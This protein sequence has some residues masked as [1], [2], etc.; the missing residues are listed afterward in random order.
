MN[1]DTSGILKKKILNRRLR[2]EG[3]LEF[4][5]TSLA[6]TK[7]QPVT[8]LLLLTECKNSFLKNIWHIKV[9]G[10]MQNIGGESDSKRPF[11]V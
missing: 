7:V 3:G 9:W 1:S 6:F 4:K 11:F 5:K 2:R 8:E 10:I